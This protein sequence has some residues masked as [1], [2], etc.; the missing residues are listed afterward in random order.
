[1][2]R[3]FGTN[4]NRVSQRGSRVVL[5]PVFLSTYGSHDLLKKVAACSISPISRYLQRC[6]QTAVGM[7][8]N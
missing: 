4:N 6:S 7:D 1:M 8:T 2:V 3:E 5:T